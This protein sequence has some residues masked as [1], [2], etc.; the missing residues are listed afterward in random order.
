MSQLVTVECAPH[1]HQ[2][3]LN[4]VHLEHIAATELDAAVKCKE[5][6]G[7]ALETKCNLPIRRWHCKTC[8]RPDQNPYKK[9]VLI[10][11]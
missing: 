10:T 5:V 3:A 9:P 6:K 4:L 8:K 2:N 7:I 11:G 1:V